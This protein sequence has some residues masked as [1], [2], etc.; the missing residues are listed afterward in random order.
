MLIIGQLHH[1]IFPPLFNQIQI[2]LQQLIIS[3]RG[4]CASSRRWETILQWDYSL[5]PICHWEGGFFS[6]LSRCCSICPKEMWQLFHPPSFGVVQSLFKSVHDD[7]VN[8]LSLSISLRIGRS[9]I[10]ILY[11]QIRTIFPESFAIKLKAIVWDEH[12]RNPELCNNV[13]PNEPF[14]VYVLDISQ[15]LSFDSLGKIICTDK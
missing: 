7:L 3:I 10:P 15:R 2:L 11:T 4:E 1:S 14:D 8:S 5:S 9:R 6:G 12:I 13:L